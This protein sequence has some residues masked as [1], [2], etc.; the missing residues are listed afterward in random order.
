M[1]TWTRAMI[2]DENLNAHFRATSIGKDT[3]FSKAKKTT[4]GLGGR[5]P[6]SNITHSGQA[7]PPKAVKKNHTKKLDCFVE[8]NSLYSK[9]D[10]VG[11]I[12]IV[13][14]KKAGL[15]GGGGR[16]AL[17]D[18]TNSKKLSLQ[19][20]SKKSYSKK[21]NDI[22]EEECL[23]NHHECIKSQKSGMDNKFLLKILGFDDDLSMQLSTPCLVPASVPPKVDS[24]APLWHL[25]Y[26]EPPELLSEDWFPSR[27]QTPEH[28][29]TSPFQNRY[30][31]SPTLMLLLSP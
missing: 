19:Q 3:N 10:S 13:S 18:L 12:S 26:D 23:H 27:C 31:S 22:A 16:R 4:T 28:P 8:E 24:S 11:G 30:A 5:K 2:Q 21:L 25:E 6:L 14:Q 9:G 15:G 20:E 29:I 7:S 1:A 17:S